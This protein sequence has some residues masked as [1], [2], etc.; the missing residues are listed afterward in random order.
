MESATLIGLVLGST[1]LVELVKQAGQG[2][3]Q[4]RRAKREVE[5]ERDRLVMSRNIWQEHALQ[6]RSLMLE[7]GCKPPDLPEDTWPSKRENN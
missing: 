2:L 5:T 7:N 4:R 6:L 1:V 3:M